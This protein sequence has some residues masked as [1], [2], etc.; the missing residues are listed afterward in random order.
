MIVY[1]TDILLLTIG[2]NIAQL[3]MFG[4]NGFRVIIIKKTAP[5]VF[6]IQ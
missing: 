6:M 1:Y 4:V 2:D 5:I 3:L